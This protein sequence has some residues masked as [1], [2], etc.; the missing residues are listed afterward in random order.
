MLKFRI[1]QAG[2]SE[3]HYQTQHPDHKKVP[4][5]PSPEAPQARGFDLK[6]PLRLL[7]AASRRRPGG[8]GGVPGASRGGGVPGRPGGVRG[9]GGAFGGVRGVSARLGASRGVGRPRDSCPSPGTR[10]DAPGTPWDTIFR[11]FRHG[12][13]SKSAPV[14]FFRDCCT[15]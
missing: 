11:P 6:G 12:A 5:A 15:F 4:E 8:V 13:F 14:G 10:R 9:V 3:T 7:P 1:C 2:K